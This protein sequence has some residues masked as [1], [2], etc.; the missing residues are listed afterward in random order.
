M[1]DKPMHSYDKL[2]GNSLSQTSTPS[3]PSHSK[4]ESHSSDDDD[5]I[6]SLQPTVII[7][8]T[9]AVTEPDRILRI[10]EQHGYQAFLTAMAADLHD[11]ISPKPGT[12]RINQE[13][14]L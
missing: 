14:K 9:D 2:F 5:K 3:T 13:T 10:L 1:T 4:A 7:E 12:G 11:E 6:L 8:T